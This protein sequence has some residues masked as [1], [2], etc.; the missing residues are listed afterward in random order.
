LADQYEAL[1]RHTPGVVEI[2][3]S[4]QAGLPELRATVNRTALS[5][6]GV[7][8]TTVSQAMRTAVQG[9]VATQLRADDQNQVN[10]RVLAKR[11]PNGSPVNLEEIPVLSSRG[12]LVR[13]GQVAK[14]ESSTGPSQINRSDRNRSVSVNGSVS[15]RTIGDVARDVR[16]AQRTVP[17]PP[18]YRVVIGG[19]AQQLDRALTALLSALTLS[20]LLMYMLMA[21]LYESF[22]YPLIVL[23]ALPLAMV[24]A[25]GGLYLTGKTLNIFSLIGIIMLTGV[26]SKNAI[27]LVDYTNTLRKE[28]KGVREALLAAGPIRLRPIAMTSCTLICSMLPLAI[29]V[30]PGGETRS[31]MAVVIIGGMI[32]STLLTLVFVPALYTYFDDLQNLP[33]RI[34]AW[35]ARRSAARAARK[36]AAEKPVAIPM[37]GAAAPTVVAAVA[38]AVS[39]E[40]ALTADAAVGD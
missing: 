14:I 31:P 20:I 19:G 12:V 15:G 27:L 21:A 2:N 23:L 36:A 1:L 7:T 10:V 33:S 40:P 6:L 5:D 28:G 38:P 34:R 16:A 3:N 17:T 8:S 26:V 22:L 24:G 39:P 9:S 4:G 35:S 32:T 13:L 37:P 30:G 18:G 25:L 11:D 29:G